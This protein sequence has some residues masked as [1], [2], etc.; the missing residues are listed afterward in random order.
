MIL[1]D[2]EKMKSEQKERNPFLE[3]EEQRQIIPSS[4]AM[5]EYESP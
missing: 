4:N 2:D 3:P 5:N 1:M